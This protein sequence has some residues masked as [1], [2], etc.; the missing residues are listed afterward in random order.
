[1]MRIE[2][3]IAKLEKR[4]EELSE[5]IL[6]MLVDEEVEEVDLEAQHQEFAAK[7]RDA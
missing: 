7:V 5:T 2:E 1:M 3:R 4:V 6:A